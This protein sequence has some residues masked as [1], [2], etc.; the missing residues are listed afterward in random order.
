MTKRNIIVV[1]AGYGGITAVLRL[2]KLLRYDTRY[3]IHLI[4]K[5]PYHTLKTQ[6]HEAAI[7]RSEVAIPIEN[8]IKGKDIIFHLTTLTDIDIANSTVKLTDTELHFEYLLL[9]LG[10]QANYYSIEGLREHSFTLQSLQDAEKIY[11]HIRQLMTNAV[12]D[13]S[14]QKDILRFVIGGGGLSGVEFAGELSDYVSK[15]AK[16]FGLPPDVFE[17]ILIEAGSRIV[18][19]ASESL[20]AEITNSLK[21]KGIKI[22]TDTKI[23]KVTPSLVVTSDGNEIKTKTVIWT[24]GIKVTDIFRLA[25]L[26][27][28]QLD[29][30]IVN[31]Y[32]QAEGFERIFAIGDNALFINKQTGKPVSASAQ[33]AL[34]QGKV[35][36]LNIFNH[37]YKKPLQAFKPKLKGEVISLGMHLAVG[38]LALP[39][40]QKITFFG[41]LA[42]LLKYAVKEKH[43]LSLKLASKDWL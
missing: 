32:L 41:F 4:D 22:L 25:G 30:I 26:K 27:T 37:I 6:L 42:N 36:A 39:F 19:T 28:G 15:H 13:P 9:A 3:Q 5:N 33:F 38:W 24:G 10:S 40:A 7:R 12:S 34:Q 17:I 29:R 31:E 21:A 11:S 8:I 16:T 2:H 35:C 20:S 14:N 18:S 23:L 1:G 43:L